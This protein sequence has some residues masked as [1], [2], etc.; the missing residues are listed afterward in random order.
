MK[1]NLFV[2]H[3]KRRRNVFI[4]EVISWLTTII[5][6]IIIALFIS[7]NIFSLTGIKGQSMEPTF[8]EDERVINYKLGYNFTAPKRNQ[9][10][11]INRYE[12]Q[13]R[14]IV[15][16]II[17]E[18]K[19]IITNILNKF[20]N[21]IDE[22]YIIKRVIGVP[23]DI[24]DI[25]DGDVYL[26]GHKLEED[27]IKGNTFAR[28]DLGYPLTIP[29][30]KVFVLGDNREHSLDSRDL[31]LIDYSQVKGKVTFRIWPLKSIS[32]VS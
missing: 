31:G 32:K 10:V 18:G 15:K 27:Y 6:T 17:N 14:G 24:I 20:T 12:G 16:N 29:E 23:G 9:I 4:R 3:Q 11:I 13:E 2:S 5:L 8:Y 1:S 7:G 22:K 30:D 26:N 25:K 21:N 28:E 19:D